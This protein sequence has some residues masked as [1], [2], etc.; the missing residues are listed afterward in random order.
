MDEEPE[1]KNQSPAY[2]DLLVSQQFDL[3]D[4]QH[5]R[6]CLDVQFNEKNECVPRIIWAYRVDETKS[7]PG[8]NDLSG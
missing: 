7:N 3:L 5:S 8:A 1:E 2:L 4:R 6:I